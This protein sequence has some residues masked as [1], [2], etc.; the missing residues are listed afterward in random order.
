M[1]HDR[2]IEL[3]DSSTTLLADHDA[4]GFQLWMGL[5]VRNLRV[6][7]SGNVADIEATLAPLV[8][9][10]ERSQDPIVHAHVAE[11]RAVGAHVQ[12]DPEVAK[13]ELARAVGW[14]DDAGFSVSCFAHGLDHTSLWALSVG[15]AEL[16]A[17][18]LGG[19][20]AIRRANLNATAPAFQRMWHDRAMADARRELG[21]D[22]FDALYAEGRELSAGGCG[23]LVIEAVGNA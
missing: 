22:R 18:L 5:F 3:L 8:E 10:A 2:V 23:R 4:S 14:Y 6:L 16:A 1:S 20:V 12:D 19:A 7:Q 17:R 15:E 21:D 13:V 9:L 11:V